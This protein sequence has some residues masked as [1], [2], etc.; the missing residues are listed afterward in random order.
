MKIRLFFIGFVVMASLLFSSS[1]LLALM[2]MSAHKSEISEAET[3]T[4]PTPEEASIKKSGKKEIDKIREQKRKIIEKAKEEEKEKNL[5]LKPK[6]PFIIDDVTFRKRY[7]HKQTLL[8]RQSERKVVRAVDRHNILIGQNP[9]GVL[10]TLL[11]LVLLTY[12]FYKFISK[13]MGS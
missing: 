8:D 7:S 13:K 2:P 3:S 9:L 4:T 1:S 6:K 12:F 5:N 11:I 10:A